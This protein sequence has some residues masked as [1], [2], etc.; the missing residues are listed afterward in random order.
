MAGCTEVE[1][2]PKVGQDEHELE[3]DGNSYQGC[4]EFEKMI[5][6]K[7]ILLNRVDVIVIEADPLSF[8]KANNRKSRTGRFF[9]P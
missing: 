2:E 6:Q 1:E 9:R 4:H 7:K 5:I 8:H 3:H